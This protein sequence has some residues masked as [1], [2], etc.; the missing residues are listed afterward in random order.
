[1]KI[2]YTGQDAPKTYTK[3]I[4]L[5]GPTPRDE[6]TPSW[7]PQM[8]KALDNAGYDGVVFLPE[9]EDGAPRVDYT[10]QVEWE[11]RHL[12]MA[13]QIL[14]WVPR[15][16]DSMPAFT[17]NVEFGRYIQSGKVM[18]GRPDDAPK[19]RYLDWLYETEEGRLS[20]HDI[21]DLA[22]AV[23]S[24][25]G[26]GCL[27]SDGERFVPLT[28][29]KTK[30]F[31]RWYCSQ[32][33]AGNTLS[34]ARVL[35]VFR[36]RNTVFSYALW[37]KVWITKEQRFKENEFVISRP[38]IVVILPF[39]V[40]GDDPFDT[41]VVLVKEYR[42]PVRN[43]LGFVMEL[44]GGSSVQEDPLS[45]ASQELKEEIGLEVA[46]ER[47][48][49]VGTRQLVSTLL[50]HTATVYAVELTQQEIDELGQST[51][52]FGV[53]EDSE[54]TY[55]EVKTL[56]QIVNDTNVDWSMVGMIFAGMNRHEER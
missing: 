38:D 24:K 40:C 45:V 11:R 37:A 54:R 52:S 5:A 56:R 39:C 41:K 23:V 2:V 29:W 3:S 4:F 1:M 28:I 12:Q 51:D 8:V 15:D 43:E 6:A 48:Y 26:D 55:T 10:D 35:W 47:F 34:D 50:S 32:R 36:T 31:Q 17:T 27:R 13:D 9:F 46:T 49:T 7:R 53:A 14:F 33:I 16:L 19:N 21:S 42:T 20:F 18:Y 22:R 30:Q 25:L 44:P